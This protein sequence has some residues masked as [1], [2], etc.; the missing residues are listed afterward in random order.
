MIV[1]DQALIGMSLEASLEEAGFEIAGPFMSKVQAL[2]WLESGAPDVALLDIM[3]QDGT[4]LDI[5]RILKSRGIPFAVYSGLP[6]KPDCPPEL[7]GVPWLEKPVSREV[8]VQVLDGLSDRMS[9]PGYGERQDH[10]QDHVIVP[11]N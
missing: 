8:L 5:A 4:S 6:H 9:S 7:C 1:E 10:V 11:G 2:N 3:I